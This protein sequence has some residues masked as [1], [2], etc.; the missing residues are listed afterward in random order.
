MKVNIV[1]KNVTVTP[2]IAEKITK[3]LNVLTKYFIIDEQDTANVLIRTYPL[4]QKIEVT[5]P[6]KYAILRAEVVDD[7]LYA[8][9][10]LVID[11]LED[12][13]RRQKT[14]IQ[15]KN[16]TSLAK[17]FV[18]QEAYEA[19]ED[20]EEVVKTKSIVCKEMSLDEAIMKM[21]LLNHDFFIYTDDETQKIA[22]VYKRNDGGYGLIETE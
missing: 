2:A 22:V 19:E 21:E 1:G 4:K 15:K 13:I 14:R 16:K 17:A 12:Q 20:I 3:K 11:K 18:E 6:T 10:D 8:A 5:I 9:I 7:D